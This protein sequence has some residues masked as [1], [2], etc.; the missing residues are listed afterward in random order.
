MC[1]PV[2]NLEDNEKK[3]PEEIGKEKERPNPALKEEERMKPEEINKGN[4][5]IEGLSMG[6]GQNLI[7]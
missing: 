4:E 1:L 2:K 6:N 3:K 5:S 7:L